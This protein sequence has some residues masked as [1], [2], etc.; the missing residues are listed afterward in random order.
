VLSTTLGPEARGLSNIRRVKT[1]K[2]KRKKEGKEEE[3]EEKEEKEEEGEEEVEEEKQKEEEEGGWR[4][5]SAVKSTDCS[6]E[7]SEFKSQQPHG[8]L[9]PSLMTS[10]SLSWCV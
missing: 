8:G 9:Q 5:G 4:D 6:S 1:A 10:D 3:E 7:G 2:T